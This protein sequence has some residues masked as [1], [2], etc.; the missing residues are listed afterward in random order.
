MVGE[1]YTQKNACLY[2]NPEHHKSHTNCFDSEYDFP[3]YK[4]VPRQQ[5]GC[6]ISS[7]MLYNFYVTSLEYSTSY[8]Y[9]NISISICILYPDHEDVSETY[10]LYPWHHFFGLPLLQ[11]KIMLS[12][13]S[14]IVHL[15]LV[16]YWNC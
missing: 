6:Y 15:C 10:H 11:L 1:K 7:E 8:M 14:H 12:L 16:T 9:F 2:S 5:T 3:Q 4:P 13:T